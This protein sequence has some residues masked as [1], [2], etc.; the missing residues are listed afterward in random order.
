MAAAGRQK[1][2]PWRSSFRLRRWHS[3]IV[4]FIILCWAQVLFLSSGSAPYD[5]VFLAARSPFSHKRDTKSAGHRRI[6]RKASF[7]RAPVAEL[8]GYS[9]KPIVYVYPQF[10]SFPENDQF[11][12]ENYTDWDL[13]SKPI[14]NSHGLKTFRPGKEVGFYDLLDVA[15]RERWTNMI[16]ESL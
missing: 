2:G 14:I 13:V 5:D 10:H 15:T 16:S 7:K 9:I 11:F 1:H 12:G 3:V 4:V 8:D 6:G